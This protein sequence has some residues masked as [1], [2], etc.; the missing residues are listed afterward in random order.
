VP[1]R[2]TANQQHV[3]SSSACK[4][5]VVGRNSTEVRTNSMIAVAVCMSGMTV[6]MTRIMSV[7]A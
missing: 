4:T 5:I 1:T 6:C 2:T 3:R 7:H